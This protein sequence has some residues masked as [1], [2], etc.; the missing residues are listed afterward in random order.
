MGINAY[1]DTFKFT[2]PIFPN[3][4]YTWNPVTKFATW[5][6]TVATEEE[7]LEAFNTT[8]LPMEIFEQ[9][10]QYVQDTAKSGKTDYHPEEV[11]NFID[12]GTWTLV[13]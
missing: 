9:F 6:D 7:I 5:E 10:K 11:Q 1:T 13:N 4:V 12:N 3:T 8:G 2:T